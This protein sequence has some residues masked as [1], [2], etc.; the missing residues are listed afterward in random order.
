M[1]L[2]GIRRE[3]K[4]P[5][6]RRVPL[7]PA[8]VEKMCKQGDLQITLQP[9]PRRIFTDQEFIE[10]GAIINEDL[11]QVPII[12]GVKEIPIQQLAPNKTYM[13]FSHT[14]KGQPYNM[15]MLKR[16]LDLGCTLI[17]Y[18]LITDQHGKRLVFFGQY[19]G[20]AGMIDTLWAFGKRLATEGIETP[21]SQI[22]PAYGYENLEQAKTAVSRLGKVLKEDKL[23]ADLMPLVFGFT[24]YGNVSAGAQEIFDLLEPQ[25]LDP[26][27]LLAH[28]PKE[29]GVFK[30]VFHEHHMVQPNSGAFKLDDYYQHP[31][32]YSPVFERYLKH[33]DVLVNCIYWEEKYPRLVTLQ[34]LQALYTQPTPKLRVI[35]D[36]SCD[37]KGSIEATV[38]ATEPDNP[39]YVY[40]VTKEKDID[41]FEGQGPVILA[42]DNLPA[43]LPKEASEFFSTSLLPFVPAIATAKYSGP[44]E[45][46]GLPDPIR[47]AVIVHQGKLTPEFNYLSHYL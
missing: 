44:F 40:D 35:S 16:L 7:V 24:G 25:T 11:E 23:T 29:R 14:I 30:V 6:E 27:E 31:E 3:D 19:A 42:V 34:D 20:L 8:H 21:F 47:R 39:V 38:R 33:L 28:P 13:F 26:L 46:C 22:L 43:E 12:F 18:E 2:I 17:D 5:F 4:N 32:K 10:A 41:G 1:H 36:I 15:P 45:S 37:I 9:S